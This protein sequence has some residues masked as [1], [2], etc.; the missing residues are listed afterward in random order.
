MESD[1]RTGLSGELPDSPVLSF[2]VVSDHERHPADL[3][4]LLPG[5]VE[6]IERVRQFSADAG[7]EILGYTDP[8][9]WN[10]LES[11]QAADRTK[12]F[13]KG[14][15]GR[16]RLVQAAEQVP[17]VYDKVWLMA[18]PW[19]QV[20]LD[21]PRMGV[22]LGRE[23]RSLV[24]RALVPKGRAGEVAGELVDALRQAAQVPGVLTGYVHLDS[25]DDPYTKI[26]TGYHRMSDDDFAVE[27][28]GYYW[29]VLLTEGHIARLGGEEAVHEAPCAS[30]E[31]VD[32]PTGRALLCTLTESP[33]H[34][35]LPAIR[36]WEEFLRPLKR[37]GYPVQLGPLGKLGS[38]LH[39]PVW[40]VEGQ[41]ISR[42]TE[43]VLRGG[44]ESGSLPGPPLRWDGAASARLTCRLHPSEL[45]DEEA[46]IGLT[47][48][49]VNAWRVRGLEGRLPEIV[50]GS[51]ESCSSSMWRTD[52]TG[53]RMLTWT[54][55]PGAADAAAA[56]ELLSA[57][58]ATVGDPAAY[59]TIDVAASE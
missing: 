49:V 7:L 30:V 10:M 54:F 52:E 33:D 28:H 5:L 1:E 46:D 32:T 45:F 27:V 11:S 34:L 24:G 8:G 47:R 19:A 53:R 38:P 2:G 17:E 12:T 3:G 4:V 44:P 59:E 29:T 13:K 48:G 57:A 37:K 51:F 31:P 9:H 35:D 20:T 26:V 21:M 56:L 14:R 36:R 15:L 42:D 58:L 39:R 43:Q 41:A 50:G 6:R 18:D 23:V 40:L 16:A 22:F 25:V 55:A